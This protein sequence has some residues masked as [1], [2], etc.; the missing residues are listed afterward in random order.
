[1]AMKIE[2]KVENSWESR[3]LGNCFIHRTSA[4]WVVS[5]LHSEGIVGPSDYLVPFDALDRRHAHPLAER[6]KRMLQG[7][8][9]GLGDVR[10]VSAR[11]VAELAQ[12]PELGPLWVGRTRYYAPGPGNWNG[13]GR[14]CPTRWQS[15][16]SYCALRTDRGWLVL[17]RSIWGN[18]CGSYLVP[19]DKVP[20]RGKT[21]D[22]DFFLRSLRHFLSN[23]R[24]ARK[25][26]DSEM[27]QLLR[28]DSDPERVKTAA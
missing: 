11:E 7:L 24:G 20:F 21:W 2:R 12:P 22:A 9:T 4:G 23:R 25:L 27:D 6:L 3:H 17:L 19:F 26:D 28:W 13:R 10:R 18:P 8:I 1:M 5:L 16:L 14:L 15:G